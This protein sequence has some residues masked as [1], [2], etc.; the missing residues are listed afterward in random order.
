MAPKKII[1]Q[2]MKVMKKPSRAACTDE[3]VPD[4]GP[5]G[6]ADRKQFRDFKKALTT[7]PDHVKDIIASVANLGYVVNKQAKYHDSYKD[8]RATA[9]APA[10]SP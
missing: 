4:A 1:K 2:V 8:G 6:T 5:T 10:A 3:P 7:A 9:G